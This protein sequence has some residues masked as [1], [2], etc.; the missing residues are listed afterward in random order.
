MNSHLYI[1]APPLADFIQVMWYDAGYKNPGV[2]RVLPDGSATLI[3]HLG[4]DRLPV[5]QAH[6]PSQFEYSSG[7]LIY[8]AHSEIFVIDTALPAAIIGVQFRPGGTF[9]F[10]P[11]PGDTLHNQI[12]PLDVL[13][14]VQRTAELR[15]RLLM[16]D[17]V[18]A[19][20]QLMEQFL[21]QCLSAEDLPHPAVRFAVSQFQNGTQSVAQVVDQI[22]LSQRHFIQ[23]FRQ[24]VGL[25]P[26]LFSRL[27]RFQTVIRQVHPQ[28][29]I[30][31]TEVAL[32]C[33]YYDQAHFIHDFQ[34]FS[35][36]TPSAYWLQRSDRANHVIF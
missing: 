13:W 21:L 5:F 26:K 3:L 15:E 18:A 22:G 20:F 6:D 27:Q 34:V 16:A 32:A 23:H 28:A 31:W 11:V 10:L 12:V 19:C 7:S 4:E 2:E 35:G 33:G 30:N 14:G 1:P 24:Q 17:T 25:T 36:L 8:G 29:E 9:P